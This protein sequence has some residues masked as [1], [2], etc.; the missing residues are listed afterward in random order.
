MTEDGAMEIWKRS[1]PRWKAEGFSL[2]GYF[3]RTTF[4]LLPTS[5]PNIGVLEESL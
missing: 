3:P 5:A 4:I 2:M 1:L